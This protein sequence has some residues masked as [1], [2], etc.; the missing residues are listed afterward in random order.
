M[1]LMTPTGFP[2]EDL[3]MEL[4]ERCRGLDRDFLRE[5][6]NFFRAMGVKIAINNI[7]LVAGLGP[8]KKPHRDIFYYCHK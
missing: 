5:E 1:L 8:D 2:P 3:Y 4:T 7:C 6:M